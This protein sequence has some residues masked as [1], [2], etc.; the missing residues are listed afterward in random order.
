[1]DGRATPDPTE[2]SLWRPL[3]L[4]QAAMDGDI[5]FAAATGGA[6]RAATDFDRLE[7]GALAADCVARAIARGVY[8]AEPLPFPGALPSWKGRFG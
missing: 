2:H 7:I 6:A 4:L 1:M 5:V 3:R 8:E